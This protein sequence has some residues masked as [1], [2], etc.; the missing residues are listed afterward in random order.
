MAASPTLPTPNPAPRSANLLVVDHDPSTRQLLRDFLDHA[1]FATAEAPD[2]DTALSRIA[3][4]EPAAIVLHDHL[5]GEQGLEILHVLRAHHPDL[6]VVF[7]AHPRN[8]ETRAAA[9]RQSPTAY[10]DKPF[11]LTEL[12]S[13]V[14]RA[15]PALGA[16]QNGSQRAAVRRR[17][18]ISARPAELPR[19]DTA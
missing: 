7:I 2:V 15:V 5:P 16:R 3:S 13:T 1:G 12:L 14:R 18:T 10:L 8:P 4:A 19:A 17:G 9:A 6:P 11:H